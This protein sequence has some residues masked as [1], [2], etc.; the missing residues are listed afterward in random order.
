MTQKAKFYV[1]TLAAAVERAARVAPVKGTAYD[2]AAG[3]KM[4]VRTDG[5]VEIMASDLETYYRE[6]VKDVVEVGDENVS[7]RFPAHLL[8]GLLS[9]L[10]VGKEVTFSQDKDRPE[11]IRIYCGKKQAKL[12]QMIGGAYPEWGRVNASD[13]KPVDAFGVKVGQVAW[14]T[15]AQAA[16]FTGINFDGERAT[17]TDRYKLAQVPLAMPVD[18][19]LTVPMNVLAPILKNMPGEMRIGGTEKEM[20]ITVGDEIEIRCMVYEQPYPDLS[21]PF[22]DNFSHVARLEREVLHETINSMLVLVKNER[23]PVMKF[24]FDYEAEEL[25]VHMSVP[26]VGEMEDVLDFQGVEGDGTFELLFTPDYVMRALDAGTGNHIEWKMGPDASGR[27]GMT[28]LTEN[29][30]E[31]WVMPREPGSVTQ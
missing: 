27:N 13:L 15:D 25:L 6:Q 24:S 5:S 10:P 17:A 7:W 4:V 8:N 29:E 12:R 3:I 9:S 30:Y 18:A 19:P 31:A 14:A 22:R 1:A 21:K 2:K 16:P 26:E 28:L 20:L 23:Y 11:I